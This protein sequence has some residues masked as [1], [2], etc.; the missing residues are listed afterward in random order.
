MELGKEKDAASHNM[1][2]QENEDTIED[3]TI[4]LNLSDDCSIEEE[5]RLLMQ[6]QKKI[7][8]KRR[9]E[10]TWKRKVE[11]LQEIEKLPGKISHREMAIHFGIPRNTLF[12]I[13]RAR[14]RIIEAYKRNPNGRRKRL[15]SGKAPHVE[16]ALYQWYK[17]AKK[18]KLPLSNV[19]LFEKARDLAVSQG[20]YS[21]RPTT[22]WLERWKKR[23]NITFSVE[24]YLQGCNENGSGDGS[25]DEKTIDTSDI[26][27]EGNE[28]DMEDD[29]AS[30]QED[31]DDNSSPT[32]QDISSL[33]QIS[34]QETDDFIRRS[35]KG[36]KRQTLTLRQK[37]EIVK[38][39]ESLPMKWSLRDM[40]SFFDVPKTTML[41]MM[42]NRDIIIKNYIN[43]PDKERR[44]NK[45][46]KAPDI[47]DALYV[48]Y[49]KVKEK[50]LPITAGI[51]RKKAKAIALSLGKPDF[52]PTEGWFARWKKRNNVTCGRPKQYDG[53]ET[54]NVLPSEYDDGDMQLF[55]TAYEKET[56]TSLSLRQKVEI[57]HQ[58]EAEPNVKLR[59]WVDMYNVSKSTLSIIKKNKETI[60][61][62]F[63]GDPSADRKRMRKGSASEVEEALF[64][65]YNEV[66]DQ[67]GPLTGPILR[68]KAKE[69][70]EVL[71]KVDFI[72]TS[73]WL[74]TWKRKYGLSEN[75]EIEQDTPTIPTQN[76]VQPSTEYKQQIR[77]QFNEEHHN[78]GN[79]M[80]VMQTPP[81]VP[82]TMKPLPNP[83]SMT[84]TYSR[85][86]FGFP[87]PSTTQESIGYDGFSRGPINPA[88]VTVQAGNNMGPPVGNGGGGQQF[89]S[90]AAANKFLGSHIY[91]TDLYCGR[92]TFSGNTINR[93]VITSSRDHTVSA[94]TA[95]QGNYTA[96]RLLQQYK[97]D[98]HQPNNFLPPPDGLTESSI[99]RAM[100]DIRRYLE[101]SP[102]PL[103]WSLVHNFEM[104]L[105]TNI[106][107]RNH[108]PL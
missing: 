10:I 22:G 75:R 14:D 36:I 104:L 59:E 39:V 52:V 4:V 90:V 13:L 8:P 57:I 12:N 98:N 51:L 105:H 74:D 5:V 9:A 67:N 102:Y 97:M 77:F 58:M 87:V 108:L 60:L 61:K 94:P 50:N 107:T 1:E 78:T 95:S 100:M 80:G 69:L 99:R 7:E 63:Y 53:T 84:N 83:Q 41:H 64:K 81:V 47:E 91:S 38:A 55:H 86:M 31:E 3:G 34:L 88:E 82:N 35:G 76:G 85:D 40:A 89:S 42:K 16:H 71:G 24:E 2:E 48:W 45:K 96:E 79:N 106:A 46:G 70:A 49:L 72:P 17:T 18:Q 20:S 15:R 92:D 103:D 25:D 29:Q 93:G 62:A 73:T 66:K 23:H 11:I 33:L 68:Q 56:R 6:S 43:S 21:F 26:K 101:Q 28:H 30:E 37:F 65:W 19:V 44:R 32:A 54:Q 27:D